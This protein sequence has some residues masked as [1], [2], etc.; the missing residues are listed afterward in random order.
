MLE[1]LLLAVVFIAFMVV[2]GM[3]WFFGRALEASMEDLWFI[4]PLLLT[5]GLLVLFAL[6]VERVFPGFLSSLKGTP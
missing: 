5:I 4:L 2:C 6:M 3:A 1:L